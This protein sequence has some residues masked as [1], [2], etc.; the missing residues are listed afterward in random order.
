MLLH[1]GLFLTDIY[2]LP[3]FPYLLSFFP[4]KYLLSSRLPGALA[5]H[6]KD[7]HE[8]LFARIYLVLPSRGTWLMVCFA[9]VNFGLNNR[10]LNTFLLTIVKHIA[11]FNP[12]MKSIVWPLVLELSGPIIP[13]AALNQVLF[14]RQRTNNVLRMYHLNNSCLRLAQ[15]LTILKE[16]IR[17]MSVWQVDWALYKVLNSKQCSPF[18]IF[19]L[20]SEFDK[21]GPVQ[22]S[23]L[24]CFRVDLVSIIYK[25]LIW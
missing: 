22:R 8:T 2:L 4:V 23:H 3:Q 10:T 17:N 13:A 18:Y 16:C 11:D 24:D 9:M 7:T 21:H 5:G 19:W 14:V 1:R 6:N 25:R 20:F 12:Q 15:C